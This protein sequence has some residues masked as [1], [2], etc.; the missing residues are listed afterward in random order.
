MFRFRFFVFHSSGYWFYFFV[1]CPVIFTKFCRFAF[2]YSVQSAFLHTF[3][4]LIS[5]F[6][7]PKRFG[8]WFFSYYW[9]SDSFFRVLTT[10]LSST[11]TL[12]FSLII[13]CL[14][15][16]FWLSYVFS[17]LNVFSDLLFPWLYHFSLFYN[18]RHYGEFSSFLSSSLY[19][20]SSF[21]SV[22][23]NCLLCG[24]FS[25]SIIYLVFFTKPT[26]SPHPLVF[27]QDSGKLLC[28]KLPVFTDVVV[29]VVDRLSS[30]PVTRTYQ[31][32][33]ICP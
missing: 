8:W 25:L 7:L 11:T 20:L 32:L 9:I 26:P 13:L 23:L 3:I 24:I 21:R 6:S 16:S 17:L 10:L 19:A 28:Y 18:W 5:L 15:F 1:L 22:L 2:I 12:F 33:S 30:I 29:A 4:S 31:C 14:P 27:C